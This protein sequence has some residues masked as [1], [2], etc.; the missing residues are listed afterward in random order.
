MSGGIR[1]RAALWLAAGGLLGALAGVLWA[2]LG[3]DG[4]ELGDVAI[5]T[6]LMGMLVG[7]LIAVLAVLLLDRR[8]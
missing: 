6:G 5:G 4:Y 8:R 1:S 7:L 3:S 2:V